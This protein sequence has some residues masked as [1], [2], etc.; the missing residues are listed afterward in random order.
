MPQEGE[1]IAVFPEVT[2][3]LSEFRSLG[4]EPRPDEVPSVCSTKRATG[5]GAQPRPQAPLS[6]T[7]GQA[8]PSGGPVIPVRGTGVR[9]GTRVLS[10][11]V[12]DPEGSLA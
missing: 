3:C 1:V 10:S 7:A 4:Q 6:Q 8:G 5:D 11:K 12:G 9:L 2:V